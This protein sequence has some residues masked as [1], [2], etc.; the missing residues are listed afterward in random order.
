MNLSFTR[1]KL[2]GAI[3]LF[4]LAPFPF[5]G[6]D[7]QSITPTNIHSFVSTQVF[8]TSGGSAVF[9]TASPEGIVSY[10]GD[11]DGPSVSLTAIGSG[12]IT[13]E[14]LV[15]VSSTFSY[16]IV[17][18][19]IVVNARGMAFTIKPLWITKNQNFYANSLANNFHV[20]SGNIP[21][22]TS[23]DWGISPA[24]VLEADR[25]LRRIGLQFQLV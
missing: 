13:L 6:T 12:T 2:L 23:F 4:V 11:R 15:F 14:A 8:S 10:D 17:S 16:V 7:A 19:E 5:Q 21:D 1:R 22:I 25:R 24:T 3:I 9:W 20:I 18:K